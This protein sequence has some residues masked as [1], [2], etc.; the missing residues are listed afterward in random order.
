LEVQLVSRGTQVFKHW[1]RILG[2]GREDALVVAET[3]STLE[4]VHG[5]VVV[6]VIKRVEVVRPVS[7]LVVPPVVWVKV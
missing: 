4:V 2:Y 6:A 1:G 7:M 5:T 3:P